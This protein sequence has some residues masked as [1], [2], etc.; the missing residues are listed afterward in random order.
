MTD[1]A[2]LRELLMRVDLA[3]GAPTLILCLVEGGDDPVEA[4]ALLLSFCRAED[5]HV[6]DL[7]VTTARQGPSVWVSRARGLP[8]DVYVV[9]ARTLTS[10]STRKMAALYNGQRQLLEAL[11]SPLLLVMHVK[12]EVILREEA[13][14]FLTWA[15]QSYVVSPVADLLRL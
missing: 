2:L 12:D 9:A 8:A 1:E 5:R 7:G 13:A 4:A 15:S 3:R 6:V 11:P 14:D 10:E